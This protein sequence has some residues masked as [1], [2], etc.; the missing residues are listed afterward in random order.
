MYDHSRPLLLLGLNPDDGFLLGGGVQWTRHGFQKEPFASRHSFDGFY[1]FSTSAF[2]FHYEG[3]WTNIIGEVDG[4]IVLSYEGPTFVQNFFGFGNDSD[5]I[6]SEDLNFYRVRKRGYGVTPSL[7]IGKEHGSSLVLKGGYESH[8]VEESA[9]RFVS[10]PGSG[11]PAS[12]FDE[13]RFV[14][15]NVGYRYRVVD[16]P[17]LTRRGIDFQI[18]GGVDL[19]VNGEE[20][21]H[22]Y[23]AASL[24]MYYQFKHLGRPV[25]ATRVGAEWHGGDYQFYQGAILGAQQNFRGVRKERFVGN[26]MFYQNTDL[27]IM[28]TRWRSYYLPAALGLQL[29]FD[30][31]RVWLDGEDSDTWHYAYGG[32]VWVSPFQT[33]LISLNYHK[34]DVDKR[35]SIG[36]GFL[37]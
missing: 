17:M 16:H 1:A 20:E 25:L 13:N 29:N 31:G 14:K 18:S 28:L 35:F 11:L 12:V 30:H 26:K 32:G 5:E 36:M 24:A 6:E 34:S 3:E 2:G 10:T 19:A 4:G 9:G 22:R 21:V 7:R 15:A 23:G 33:L 8:E 27:R 37:F